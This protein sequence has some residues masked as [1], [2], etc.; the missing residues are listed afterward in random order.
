MSDMIIIEKKIASVLS[1]IVVEGI[2]SIKS[3]WKNLI[4]NNIPE[5]FSEGPY[6]NPYRMTPCHLLLSIQ[7]SLS[8]FTLKI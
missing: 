4:K 6:T 2:Y 1:E 7:C 8:I 5:L 3:R